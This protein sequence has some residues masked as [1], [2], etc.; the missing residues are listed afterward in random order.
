MIR[1]D[2][3]RLREQHPDW[4]MERDSDGAVVVI[5]ASSLE[6]GNRN[7]KLSVCLGNWARKDGTGQCFDSSTGFELPNGAIRSPDAAWVSKERLGEMP[8]TRRRAFPR[9]VPEF[10]AEIRSDSD[11]LADLQEKMR[12]YTD[13]GV[14]LGWLIDPFERRVHVYRAGQAPVVVDK[15]KGVSTDPVLRG[16]EL[17]LRDIRD[18][19]F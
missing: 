15:P 19:G 17:P 13:N 18:V 14:L 7:H 8:K 11:S 16:F 4:R 2:F 5:P 10:V 9:L 3:Y 6:S 12:E 1:E